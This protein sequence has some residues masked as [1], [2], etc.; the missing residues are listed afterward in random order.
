MTKANN[1]LRGGILRPNVAIQQEYVNA[2]LTMVRRLGDDIKRELK[3]V[4]AESTHHGAMDDDKGD[5]AT[6]GNVSS[7]ARIVMNGLVDKYEPLF[8]RLA[9]KSTKRMIARTI[10]NSSVTLGMSLKDMSSSVTLNTDILNDRLQEIVT[11]STAEAANLIKL[12]PQKYLGEVQGQVMRSITTGGGMQTLLP[13]L[14][15][16]YGQ[17]IRHA[18]NVAMDQTRKAYNNINAGRMQAIGVKEFEWIHT[19]GTQH[20]RKDHIDLDGKTFSLD[21]LPVIGVMYGQE[22]RGKPGDLPFCRCVMR[23]IVSFGE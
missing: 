15:E 14:T 5:R 8:N 12:I 11:A 3:R 22:V 20:P 4:F 16:K 21:D 9:K 7:Q 10:K 18:R 2:V 19:G 23:P 1:Q 17:N 6:F 13:Y